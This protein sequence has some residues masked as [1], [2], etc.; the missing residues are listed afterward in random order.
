MSGDERD[1]GERPRLSWRE[2]DQR[3]DGARRAGGEP[4]A[5][6]PR[7]QADAD[8]YLKQL[9]DT[10]FGKA[11]G[12]P[13]SVAGRLA[14]AVRDALGTPEL[15]PACRAYLEALGVPEDGALVSAFLDSREPELV[16]ATLGAL[17][18]R[19]AGG[20]LEVSSGLRAQLRMLA[21]EPDDEIAETA[22][23]ILEHL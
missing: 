16:R 8:R 13:G 5:R 9:D 12:R 4:S 22:E 21:D 18:E 11:K 20:A 15:A 14:Q 23:E 6:G 3:R 7:S 17:L 2:I 1:S 10:M 19:A